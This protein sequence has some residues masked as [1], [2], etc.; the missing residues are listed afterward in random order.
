V[1]FCP[2][3]GTLL[4]PKDGMLR[5]RCGY[6]KDIGEEVKE[7]YNLEEKT[8]EAREIMIVEEEL[9]QMPTCK[10]DCR[11]CGNTTAYYWMLQTRGADEPS[12]KFFR[13][14]KCKYTWRDYD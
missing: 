7:K 12:T 2:E 4:L 8:E 3:C 13:C 6:T 14:T 11:R 9:Q 1:E 5:C 10:A